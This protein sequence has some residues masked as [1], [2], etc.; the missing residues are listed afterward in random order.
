MKRLFVML[1][2]RECARQVVDDLVLNKFD[3]RGIYVLANKAVILEEIPDDGFLEPDIVTAIQHGERAGGESGIIASL[4]AVTYPPAGVVMGGGLLTVIEK[5][6]TEVGSI[7]KRIFGSTPDDRWQNGIEE[8]EV[9]LTIDA[10]KGRI[11]EIQRVVLD[12]H[13]EAEFDGVEPPPPIAD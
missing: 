12:H 9:M 10:P 13:P 2:D 1:P 5:L 3:E 7:L 4:P 11:T 8:G 6:E